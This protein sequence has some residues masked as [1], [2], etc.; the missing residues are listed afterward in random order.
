MP[1]RHPHTYRRPKPVD[2]AAAELERILTEE[3]VPD[4]AEPIRE[5]RSI[6]YRPLVAVIALV[7]FGLAAIAFILTL[8]AG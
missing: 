2:D 5:R 4:D 1:R 6:D 7:I 8:R 3:Q